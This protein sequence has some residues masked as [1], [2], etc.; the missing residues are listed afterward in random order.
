MA[1]ILQE[2]AMWELVEVARTTAIFRR[3]SSPPF[4]TSGDDWWKQQ[5]NQ[6]RA[7]PENPF[8]LDD[9]LMQEPFAVRVQ[10]YYKRLALREKLYRIK[11][12]LNKLVGK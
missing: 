6:R 11:V 4:T 12:R 5:Y 10:N 2:D 8:R 3:T 1:D 7:D 9:G